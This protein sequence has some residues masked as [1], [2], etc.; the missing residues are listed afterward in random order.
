M[1]QGETSHFLQK[2]KSFFKSEIYIPEALPT[3][4]EKLQQF[5]DSLIL[6]IKNQEALSTKSNPEQ[7]S[8]FEDLC[9]AIAASEKFNEDV[10]KFLIHLPTK[11]DFYTHSP[12]KV[13]ES[14]WTR[15]LIEPRAD[16][17]SYP[18]AQSMVRFSAQLWSR[19]KAIKE[20][21]EID[22]AVS[23]ISQIG[24]FKKDIPVKI[25]P[26][27]EPEINYPLDDRSEAA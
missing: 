13:N 12:S 3:D 2:D 8:A 25:K 18:D 5:R 19:V 16:L 26:N 14:V 24:D 22:T 15:T 11:E 17:E 21:H 4:E 7:A 6:L 9:Q 1:Y 10:A 27:L 20:E 23:N